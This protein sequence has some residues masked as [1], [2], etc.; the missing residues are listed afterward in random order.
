[1]IKTRVPLAIFYGTFV[2]RVTLVGRRCLI[3]QICWSKI[4][5]YAGC[6]IRG[7]LYVCVC[8]CVC[9]LHFSILS[10]LRSLSRFNTWLRSAL[11]NSVWTHYTYASTEIRTV[12]LDTKF[13]TLQWLW[14]SR[15]C[16]FA[17]LMRLFA[18][19]RFTK[20]AVMTVGC[21]LMP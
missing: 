8:V 13:S 9:V 4:L 2:F 19:F 14:P 15:R 3:D 20:C 16:Y 21:S 17:E 10:Q 6:I 11:W 12:N 18:I 5:L 7:W 1:M